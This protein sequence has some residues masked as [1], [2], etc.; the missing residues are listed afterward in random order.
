M[1]R[2]VAFIRA[3]MVGRDG[4]DRQTLLDC[5]E[6]AGAIE[7]RSYIST[8]NV[9]FSAET[10]DVPAVTTDVE[11]AIEA[12]VLRRTE[13]YVRTVA[14]LEDLVNADPFSSSPVRGSDQHEVSFTYERIDPG[15][16]DLP[17]VSPGGHLTVFHA[18]PSEVFCDGLEIDGRRKGA[19]GFV[20]RLLDQ[21]LTTRAWSTVLRVVDDP[22][23]R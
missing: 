19:G 11:E 3:V 9:T 5:F 14:Y 16:L 7:P 18:N 15:S 4:L 1:D 6:H 23:A 2:Y 20:E 17:I 21:R 12:V 13:V 8:G 22:D 10:D